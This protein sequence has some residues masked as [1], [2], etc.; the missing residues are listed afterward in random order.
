MRRVYR[1]RPKGTVGSTKA[2]GNGSK[3]RTSPTLTKIS[4]SVNT[5]NWTMGIGTAELV[6]T[7]AGAYSWGQLRIRVHVQ[8]KDWY[9][10]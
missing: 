8:V 5:W 4:C 2:T 7:V 3:E 6:T 9:A 10:N 1:K